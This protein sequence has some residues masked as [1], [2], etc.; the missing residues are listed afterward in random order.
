MLF[1]FI[2]VVKKNLHMKNLHMKKILFLLTAVLCSFTLKA[3]IT[4]T[5]TNPIYANDGVTLF[6]AT[7]ETN[8]WALDLQYQPFVATNGVTMVS[9]N[10]VGLAGNFSLSNITVVRLYNPSTGAPSQFSAKVN[11]NFYS[12]DATVKFKLNVAF[13]DVNHSGGGNGTVEFQVNTK[14][15]SRPAT[16]YYSAAL[17]GVYTRNNCS[18]G[19]VGSSNSYSVPAGSFTSTISQADANQK[20][21]N[22]AQA[23]INANGTCSLDYSKWLKDF[24][25][26]RYSDDWLMGFEWN[27]NLVTTPTIRL[28]IYQDGVFRGVLASNVPNT[29]LILG[30]NVIQYLAGQ[31]E[32]YE[33]LKVKIISEADEN[34]TDFSN[35]S[36]WWMD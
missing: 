18:V 21:V 10:I 15:G 32:P 16:V 29:G 6:T 30:V 27:Q 11:T 2:Y 14:P 33:N 35:E 12:G 19:Y 1:G 5:A 13:V 9:P 24:D 17:S 36:D 20:A 34:I 23:D 4:F 26:P 8:N 28:E 31:G 22:F 7:G 25:W 3:Q